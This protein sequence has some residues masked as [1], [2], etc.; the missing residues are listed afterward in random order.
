MAQ[1]PAQ[2]DPTPGEAAMPTNTRLFVLIWLCAASTLAYIHRGCMGVAATEIQNYF[3]LTD[4]EMGWLMTG[5]FITY[6]VFQIPTG[7]L[8]DYVGARVALTAFAL[9]WSLSTGVMGLAGGFSG[10]LVAR[11]VNGGAQAGLFPCAMLTIKKWFPTLR[12]GMASGCLGCFQSVGGAIAASVTG[13][14]LKSGLDWQTTFALLSVPGFLWAVGFYWWFRDRP[15]QHRSVNQAELTLIRGSTAPESSAANEQAEPTP[16]LWI[17]SNVSFWCICSQQFFR[18][19]GYIFYS[20]W[21]PKFLKE[22][23]GV[24]T[25]QAGYLTSAPLI[26]VM[27]GTL[28]GGSLTDLLVQWT[29]SR[30]IGRKLLAMSTLTVSGLFILLASLAD[31]V[32][33]EVAIISVGS[34]CSG[35]GN[36]VS[37]AITLDMG[38]KHTTSIFSAMNMVGNFGAAAF[39]IVAAWFVH[40][41]GHWTF[42]ASPLKDHAGLA[43]VTMSRASNWHSL[44][45]LFAGIYFC[46]AASWIFL[47]PNETIAETPDSTKS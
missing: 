38:G 46:A 39:P 2:F 4:V 34:F 45:Y 42:L 10:L 7:R 22:S 29:G 1:E 12:R 23:W 11:L 41:T 19:A 35:C 15:E 44:L 27:L 31:N 43:V 26:A 14:M 25:E 20:T 32:V 28:V 8:G 24:D 37:Y 6:G 30:F 9:V 13:F 5:F 16:W 21:F 17:L 33:L 40:W 36:P 3:D 18:A 47:N